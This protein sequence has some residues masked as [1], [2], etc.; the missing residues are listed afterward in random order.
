MFLR[1]LLVFCEEYW[2]VCHVL[3]IGGGGGRS[4]SFGIYPMVFIVS[5][6]PPPLTHYC[7]A[8]VWLR[9]V[10]LLGSLGGQN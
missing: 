9:R 8:G 1:V 5:L 4:A 3:E 6:C 10:A 7:G 2:H